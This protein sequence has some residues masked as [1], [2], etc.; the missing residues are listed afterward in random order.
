VKA[1]VYVTPTLANYAMI[2]Q[3]ATALDEFLK[4]PNLRY[5]A[6]WVQDAFQPEANRYKNG[7][8]PALFP[9]IRESLALQRK[10]VKAL[11]DAGV[12]LMCG[13]DA[14]G[15]GPVAGFGVHEELQ[16]F[17]NDGISPYNALR[18]ATVN[19]AHYFGKS[20]EFGTI[21]PG[22]RADLLL[23]SGNPLADIHN[24]TRIE[25]VMIRGR[26]MGS[27]ELHAALEK[28]PSS[29]TQRIQQ[30]RRQLEREPESVS[31]PLE[32]EDPYGNLA[33]AALYAMVKDMP[34]EKLQATLQVLRKKLPGS[35]V[36]SEEAFNFLGY[37]LLQRKEFPVSIVILR[38]NTEDFPK[39]ANTWDSLADAQFQSGDVVHAVENYGKALEVDAKYGNA[40]F[41]RKFLQKHGAGKN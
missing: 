21:T 38:V 2:V 12:P 16:E 37:H 3:Q 5:D 7:F 34:A 40:E 17:V 33:A 35:R 14:S 1:G 27:G 18:T 24:T 22:K 13:T 9:H 32:E 41:A 8:E 30:V 26:W 20:D 31:K 28:V 39:S 19:P 15:V 11:S 10:L 25:G 23:L 6:P 36:V 4:N 29:Y